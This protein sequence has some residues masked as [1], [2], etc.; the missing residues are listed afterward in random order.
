MDKAPCP[1]CGGRLDKVDRE[2]LKCVLCKSEVW[3]SE[4]KIKKNVGKTLDSRFFFFDH[5]P[6]EI[7][8]SGPHKKGGG[9]KSGKRHTKKEGN[10]KYIEPWGAK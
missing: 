1:I 4:D 8:P 6:E 3:L 9:S 7:L 10:K 2:H 5:E